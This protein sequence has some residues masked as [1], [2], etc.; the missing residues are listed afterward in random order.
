MW[1]DN[2]KTRILHR[3]SGGGVLVRTAIAQRVAKSLSD[4]C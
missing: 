3:W 4:H 1:L 2:R